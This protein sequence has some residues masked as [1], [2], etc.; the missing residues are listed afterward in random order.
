M[1]RTRR[2]VLA[3]LPLIAAATAAMPAAAEAASAS[4]LG[5]QA[6]LALKELY[7]KQ[8][9]MQ[10]LGERAKGILVFPRIVKAGFMI[11]A[12]TGNGALLVHGS[13]IGYYNISAVSFG[14]QAGAQAFSYALFFMTDGSLDYLKSSHGWAIGTGPSVVVLDKGAA[15]SVTSTTLSQAVY[16]V[17]FSATGLMAGIG[18]EGS[19][20]TPIRPGK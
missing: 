16:A 19:K 9:H 13:A 14:L 10:A 11:G 18:L 2:R 6:A 4:E 8:P 5:Q 15:G 17:P 1:D 12:Q 7:A 20:I 3:A